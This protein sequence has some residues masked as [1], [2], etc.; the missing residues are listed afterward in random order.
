MPR[1]QLYRF[2]LGVAVFFMIGIGAKRFYAW[3][4]ERFP[5]RYKSLISQSRTASNC[6][7]VYV[8]TFTIPVW[9]FYTR[10]AGPE[11]IPSAE[12]YRRILEWNCERYFAKD[13]KPPL[14]EALRVYRLGCSPVVIGEIPMF[15]LAGRVSPQTWARSELTRIRNAGASSL[16]ILDEMNLSAPTLLDEAGNMGASVQIL[17]GGRPSVGYLGKIDFASQEKVLSPPAPSR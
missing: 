12:A 8:A 13:P 9:E 10:D 3:Q 4:Q 11:G 17:D 6:A 5:R 2:C 1:P 16:F 7:A 14:P 15:G